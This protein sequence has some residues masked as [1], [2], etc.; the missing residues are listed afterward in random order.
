MSKDD[1]LIFIHTKTKKVLK[2]RLGR[3]CFMPSLLTKKS[4]VLFW[5][6]HFFMM[7]NLNRCSIVQPRCT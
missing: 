4:Q 3:L 6:K 5:R 1:Q 7:V 2:K